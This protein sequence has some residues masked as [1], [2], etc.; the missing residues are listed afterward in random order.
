M[1]AN[2][3]RINPLIL[4]VKNE[5]ED[6]IDDHPIEEPIGN[7]ALQHINNVQMSDGDISDGVGS[8]IDADP[9]ANEVNPA[10]PGGQADPESSDDDSIGLLANYSS[11]LEPFQDRYRLAFNDCESIESKNTD[12]YA[13]AVRAAQLAG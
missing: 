4:G 13:G 9:A 12:N 2:G 1:N 5:N 11:F 6:E 3:P 10:Q 8:N 7:L